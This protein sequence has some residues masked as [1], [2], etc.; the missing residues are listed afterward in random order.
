[1]KKIKILCVDDDLVSRNKMQAILEVKG[2]CV[3]AATGQEAMAHI[4]KSLREKERFD[5]ITLDIGLPDHDGIEVL[6]RIRKMEKGSGLKDQE[7]AKII[8]VTSHADKE[9]VLSCLKAGCNEYI[10]KPFDITTLVGK[11]EK[12]GF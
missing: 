1:M 8:M 5:L 12:I 9:R 4:E 6:Q 2:D 10:V 3:Q 7:R 11:M